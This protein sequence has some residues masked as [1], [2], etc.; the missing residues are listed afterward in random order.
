MYEVRNKNKIKKEKVLDDFN[1]KWKVV[2]Y[3]VLE[4]NYFI[5]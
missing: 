3:F 1:M 4:L 2:Y 5:I